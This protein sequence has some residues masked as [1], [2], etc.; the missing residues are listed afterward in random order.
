MQRR[1]ASAAIRLRGW[2]QCCLRHQCCLHRLASR[3]EPVLQR[4]LGLKDNP[5][6]HRPP[7]LEDDPDN[8]V[9]PRKI[10]QYCHHLHGHSTPRTSQAAAASVAWLQRQSSPACPPTLLVEPDRGACLGNLLIS[11]TV[12]WNDLGHWGGCPGRPFFSFFYNS[13]YTTNYDSGGNGH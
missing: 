6:M 2:S 8:P 7:V 10:I 5:V 9:R 3:E 1:H 11:I 4:P 12:G 13:Q